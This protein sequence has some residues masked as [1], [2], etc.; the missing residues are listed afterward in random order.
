[1]TV[2]N[3]P[4]VITT[5]DWIQRNDSMTLSGNKLRTFKAHYSQEIPYSGTHI[6]EPQEGWNGLLENH[7]KYIT[8]I[9]LGRG[10][11]RAMAST[12][13][14]NSYFIPAERECSI[15][16]ISFMM[17]GTSDDARALQQYRQFFIRAE[18]DHHK[19]FLIEWCINSLANADELI[20]ALI[21]L[22]MYVNQEE[23][24]TMFGSWSKLLA[25][26]IQKTGQN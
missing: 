15:D 25:K 9:D 8:T 6:L 19:K 12:L 7:G 5:T 11:C 13:L 26:Q 18:N 22:R 17:Y 10:I 3:S 4:I 14:M 2:S 23:Y 16:I 1:M 20:I 24:Y 21:N